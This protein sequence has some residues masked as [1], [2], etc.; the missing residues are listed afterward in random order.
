MENLG[1][2]L[3]DAV[4]VGLIILLS[5][6]GLLSGFTKELFNAIGLIGGLFVA[7]YYKK[8]LA[9]YLHDNFLNNLSMP[10]LELLSLLAIFIA[11]FIVAKVVYKIIESI[12]S[13]DYLSGA[14]RLGGMLVKMITLF[15]VFSLIVFGLSSKPQVVNKFKNTLEN[16]K[17]YPLLKS[18]G[19]LILN[20]SDEILNSPTTKE[21]NSTNSEQKAVT[22]T[23]EENKTKEVTPSNDTNTTESKEQNGANTTEPKEQKEVVAPKT[24]ESN[25]SSIENEDNITNSSTIKTEE[26]NKTNDMSSESN[27]T[28]Q[29]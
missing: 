15:F 18:S 7:S 25:K 14:S 26:A 17:L 21:K 29:D 8:D 23:Q 12:S 1:F 2:N 22:P 10:L 3:F 13:N 16:S 6:K 24:S 11:I 19:A 28:N 20:T 5:L 9:I 4:V 27:S